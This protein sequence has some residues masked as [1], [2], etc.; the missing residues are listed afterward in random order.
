MLNQQGWGLAPALPLAAPNVAPPSPATNLNWQ[1]LEELTAPVILGDGKTSIP[2][3]PAANFSSQQIQSQ[4]HLQQQINELRQQYALSPSMT[5]SS[6]CPNNMRR[7]LHSGHMQL[8]PQPPVPDT[9]GTG[10][11]SSRG[12]YH[13]PADAMMYVPPSLRNYGIPQSSGDA[14]FTRENDVFL[15]QQQQQHVTQSA[16][17][18]ANVTPAASM[19]Q[20]SSPACPA[21]FSLTA[22][23]SK[24]AIVRRCQGDDCQVDLTH[25][26]R[27][28]K[29]RK[30]CG[31]CISASSV[32]VGGVECRY[33][34][35]CSCLHNIT[36]FDQARRSCRMKLEKHKLRA[37]RARSSQGFPP[38]RRASASGNAEGPESSEVP[39]GRPQS[40]PCLTD[41]GPQRHSS[42]NKR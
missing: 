34:Q 10:A 39:A 15:Q 35:Q 3:A 31:N 27:Y 21:T 37:R 6:A 13:W 32:V 14:G 9:V 22:S 16:G 18:L 23:G 24:D 7:A 5:G 1:L 38:S 26:K 33:C 36:D 19:P 42:D 25:A 41:P 8:P 2:S 40:H 11:A 29:R 12:R 17:G 4:L 20:S 28:Y 30:L